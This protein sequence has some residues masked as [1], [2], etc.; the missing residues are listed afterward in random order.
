[1]V[2]ADVAVNGLFDLDQLGDSNNLIHETFNLDDLNGLNLLNDDPSDDLGHLHDVL[3]DDGYLNA[4]IKN[5]LVH[6]QNGTG[7][8]LALRALREEP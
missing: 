3:L 7:A 2:F 5:L 8:S 6:L 1:M 4:P